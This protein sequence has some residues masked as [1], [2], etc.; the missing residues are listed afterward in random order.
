MKLHRSRQ[1]HNP[2]FVGASIAAVSAL[3][4]GKL[5]AAMDEC[6]STTYPRICGL[7]FMSH[8]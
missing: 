3:W 4:L 1:R 5:P 8:L 6:L 2:T 7:L